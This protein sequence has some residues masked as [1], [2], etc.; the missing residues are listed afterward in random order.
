MENEMDKVE[1]LYARCENVLPGHGPNRTM[2]AVF[3]ELA[4][5]LEG[6]E[7]L[8][9]YGSGEYLSAFESEVAQTFGKPAAVFLP[10]GTMAQQICPAHLV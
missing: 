7:A 4:D 1:E 8:D 5:G 3:Q 10:S 2:K 6:S 9:R